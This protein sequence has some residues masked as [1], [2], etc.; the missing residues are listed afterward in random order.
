MKRHVRLII[1]IILI[2]LSICFIIPIIL[3]DIEIESIIAR[4]ATACALIANTYLLSEHKMFKNSL[5]V[6]ALALI[7]IDTFIYIYL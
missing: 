1:D 3:K 5:F 4:I 2:S 7:I 6:T